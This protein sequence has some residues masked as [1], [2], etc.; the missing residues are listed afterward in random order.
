MKPT[1]LYTSG[2]NEITDL[3]KEQNYFGACTAYFEFIHD[4]LPDKPIN[5]P[6]V[7][8]MESRAILSKDNAAGAIVFHIREIYRNY[9]NK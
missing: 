1:I 6:N 4:R 3:A 7:Y 5:H 2:I 8:F 9:V